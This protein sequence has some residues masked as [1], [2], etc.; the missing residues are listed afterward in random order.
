M[1]KTAHTKKF[2][3]D[4]AFLWY[5]AALAGMLLFCFAPSGTVGETDADEGEAVP[6]FLM[7]GDCGTTV[8]QLQAH[9]RML[10]YD[11]GEGG[12][13]GAETAAAVRRFREDCGFVGD[14]ICDA[15]VLQAAAYLCSREAD[16]GAVDDAVWKALAD[17]GCMDA[18]VGDE[19]LPADARLRNALMLYQRTH[20]LYGTGIADYATRCALGIG[21]TGAALLTDGAAEQALYDLRCCALADALS[22]F[23]A[24]YPEANE[25]YTLT[26]C[27]AVLCLRAQDERFSGGLDAVC[28]AGLCRGGD[29]YAG[30]AHDPLFLRAAEDAL[31][32][33]AVGDVR[34]LCR[35][36]LYVQP[37]GTDLP[38]DA[39]VC[40][41]TK[42]FVFF[43]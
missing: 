11:A 40:M 42:H 4:G 28:A 16:G 22:R 43:R 38:R 26:A 18:A 1:R 23:A 7:Q 33:A 29:P 25:L 39:V 5:L 3:P 9:L 41:R 20:G 14:G 15:S 32:A 2:S 35:G 12:V 6:V 31:C 37:D 19:T 13:Y 10:G 30:H 24:Q 27:A 17:A 8:G 36:A 34:D 21:G